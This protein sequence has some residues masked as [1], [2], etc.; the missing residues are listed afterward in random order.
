MN[1]CSKLDVTFYLLSLYAQG[2]TCRN[3][4]HITNITH[5]NPPYFLVNTPCKMNTPE[6]EKIIG[7]NLNGM[8]SI[9]NPVNNDNIAIEN[10]IIADAI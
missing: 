7:H 1:A 9:L 4:L 5:S 6:T 3:Q 8:K 10:N 2:Q